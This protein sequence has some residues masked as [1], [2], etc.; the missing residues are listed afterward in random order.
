MGYI[1]FELTRRTDEEGNTIVATA[2]RLS[3]DLSPLETA[4]L[5]MIAHALSFRGKVEIIQDFILDM[6]QLDNEQY[7]LG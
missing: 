3:S 7:L 1:R 5:S 2:K 6:A 4:Q